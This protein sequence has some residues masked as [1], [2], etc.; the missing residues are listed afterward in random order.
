MDSRTSI[1][2]DG[3]PT[4]AGRS[5]LERR[6]VRA[7]GRIEAFETHAGAARTWLLAA[8]PPALAGASLSLEADDVVVDAPALVVLEILPDRPGDR[9]RLA[10]ALGGP[11]APVGVRRLHRFDAGL[12]LEADARAT[13]ASFVLACIDA[14]VGA[15][16]RIRAILPLADDVLADLARDA[17]RDPS[18][19]A[20]RMLEP[21]VDAV[22]ARAPT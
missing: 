3:A 8:L 7:G 20:S 1:S 18:A 5:A 10:H 6:I 14:E 22:L 17:L 21:Y 12:V 11:G 13:P 9:E 2:F 4:A 19:D 15:A 16:R